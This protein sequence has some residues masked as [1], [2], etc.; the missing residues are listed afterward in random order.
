MRS[1]RIIFLTAALFAVHFAMHA[2]GTTTADAY[3]NLAAKQF[4]KEDKLSALKTLDKGLR[5]HPGDAKLLRLAEELLKEQENQQQQAQQQQ[6]NEQSN[7]EG[8]SEQ[9][10]SGDQGQDQK[11]QSGEPEQRSEQ[12]E[13][14]Q[15]RPGRIS[16]EDAERMLDAMDRQEKDVQEKMRVRQ[17]P[18]PRTP[19]D[20]D[21]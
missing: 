21:W 10:N 18:V 2:Q 6:Q 19:I 12:N 8:K 13:K 15:P 14:Q 16:P 7:D 5:E 17:R 1:T 4:V 9:Q 3:F 20:K 11:E